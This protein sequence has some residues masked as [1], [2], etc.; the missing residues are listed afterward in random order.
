MDEFNY[1][2]F[3]ND[4]NDLLAVEKLLADDFLTFDVRFSQT[5]ADFFLNIAAFPNCLESAGIKKIKTTT[6]TVVI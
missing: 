6:T 2:P 3:L 4:D 5:V 1:L